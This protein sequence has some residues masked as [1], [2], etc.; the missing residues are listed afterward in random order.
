MLLDLPMLPEMGIAPRYYSWLLE[1]G[2]DQN[3]DFGA[4]SSI[5]I[6]DWLCFEPLIPSAL[7]AQT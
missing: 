3:F 1:P 6:L 7:E 2:I 4:G 5:N